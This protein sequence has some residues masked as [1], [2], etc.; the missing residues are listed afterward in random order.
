MRPKKVEKSEAPFFADSPMVSPGKRTRATVQESR[1]NRPASPAASPASVARAKVNSGSVRS[2]GGFLAPRAKAKAKSER[3]KLIAQEVRRSGVIQRDDSIGMELMDAP[4]KRTSRSGED[5]DFFAEMDHADGFVNG[6][7][8]GKGGVSSASETPTFAQSPTEDEMVREPVSTGSRISRVSRSPL[9]T[10][11]FSSDEDSSPQMM[12]REA[13]KLPKPQ[14][15]K[16]TSASFLSESADSPVDARRRFPAKFQEAPL[17][18]H[19]TQH[20]GQSEPLR[21]QLFQEDFSRATQSASLGSGAKFPPEDVTLTFEPLVLEEKEPQVAPESESDEGDA[22]LS[23]DMDELPQVIIPEDPG[24]PGSPQ[25]GREDR[26]KALPRSSQSKSELEFLPV[27]KVTPSPD[28]PSLAFSPDVKGRAKDL[29]S[30]SASTCTPSGESRFMASPSASEL[31]RAPWNEDQTALKQQLEELEEQQKQIQSGLKE[32]LQHHRRLWADELQRCQ[33]T[34]KELEKALEEE[35]QKHKEQ[36]KEWERRLQSELTKK[37][38]QWREEVDALVK[39]VDRLRQRCREHLQ[40]KPEPKSTATV[41]T[42]CDEDVASMMDLLSQQLQPQAPQQDPKPSL[43][44]TTS[45]KVEKPETPK[46]VRILEAQE[47]STDVDLTLPIGAA[48]EARLEASSAALTAS[49]AAAYQAPYQAPLGAVSELW[50]TAKASS[51]LEETLPAPR[52]ARQALSAFSSPMR[53][54]FQSPSSSPVGL[55]FPSPVLVPQDGTPSNSPLKRIKPKVTSFLDATPIGPPLPS[56]TPSVWTP[57]D[58]NARAYSRSPRGLTPESPWTP[59]LHLSVER[60]PVAR[61]PSAQVPTEPVAQACG[62]PSANADYLRFGPNA[63]FEA[64]KSWRRD[65]FEPSLM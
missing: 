9:Q 62:S 40:R 49:S 1:L 46:Q 34:S 23:Q 56:F 57:E 37:E 36:I 51:Q 26:D 10:S 13:P 29:S 35:R 21:R 44:A 8:Y 43:S 41:A 12:P 25:A 17:S 55:E 19:V 53:D 5:D 11:I 58:L 60:S 50:A 48:R 52:Q 2:P 7:S 38:S 20:V 33:E 31:S 24:S 54:R 32:A 65:G 15:T 28:V 47:V 64:P 39:E 16:R 30:T 18:G 3:E 59:T 22:I 27:L 4:A 42:S 45:T 6:V 63:H 14:I 61:F